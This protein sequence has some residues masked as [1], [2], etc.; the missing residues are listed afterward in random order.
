MTY[1]RE[2]NAKT[3]SEEDIKAV[4][5]LLYFAGVF[6]S[7]RHSIYDLWNNDGTGDQIFHATMSLAG[8]QF[9]LL[10][11]SFDDIATRNFRMEFDELASVREVF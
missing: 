10:D 7:S 2:G 8:F 11:I 9:L 6:K 5:C 4:I 3:T 1:R